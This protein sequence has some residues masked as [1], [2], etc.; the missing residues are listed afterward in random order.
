[1]GLNY[2]GNEL[3]KNRNVKVAWTPE[4]LKEYIKCRDDI[5][6]FAQNY[7]KVV[8]TDGD[9]VLL[10]LYD[11]Q[12]EIIQSYLDHRGTIVNTSRQVGKT[13]VV[14]AIVLHYVLFNKNRRAAIL[15]NKEETAKGI[16]ERIQ[17]A[18]ERL[19]HWLQQGI[20]TWNK[21][22]M[23]LE[24][25]SKIFTAATSSSAIRGKSVSLLYID[26]AAHIDNWDEFYTSVFPTL[27]AGKRT[28]VI[29]TSTPKGL[30]HFHK[31]WVNAHHPR[32]SRKWN[33][34]NPVEVMWWRVPGRDE[35][36]KQ[37]ELAG[38]DFDYDKF[39]QEHE[40]EFLGSSGTLISGSKLK[41]LVHR[42]PIRMSQGLYQYEE[43]IPGHVYFL[44]A[45]VSEGKG[46]DYSAFHVIDATALP[47]RQVCVFHSNTTVPI[48]YAAMIKNT[49]KMYNTAYVL[50]ENNNS[51]GAD[52]VNYL[53]YE[54]ECENLLFTT[55]M[56]RAGKVASL[57]G[58]SRS[59]RGVKTTGLVKANGCSLA[60]LL[61]EQDRLILNDHNTIKEFYRFS[62]K[63]PTFKAEE[64]HDDLCMG[65]VLFAWLSNQEFFKEAT[66]TDAIKDM[67]EI[68]EETMESELVPFGYINDGRNHD[69]DEVLEGWVPVDDFSFFF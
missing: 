19:P 2:N 9:E 62:R 63:G 49:A 27:S 51:M 23:T 57:A 66:S 26:E 55:F 61:I 11:Y 67:R 65:I 68:D 44:V 58:T 12:K 15:A 28:K 40:C 17:F 24:N 8:T 3:L 60:K 21:L 39:A 13:T 32:D 43:P 6:Y 29:F 37:R 30:N 42:E 50:V 22:D 41:A 45:D 16:L 25:G 64:G 5:F 35:A 69:D 48:D 52:V 4:L 14:T 59:E 1:M 54:F 46:F 38:L 34:F 33:G 20:V 53:T 10:E 47:Y 7:M 56:G 36:W 18:Y 31:F